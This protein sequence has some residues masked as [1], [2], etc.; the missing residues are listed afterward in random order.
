MISVVKAAVSL[1]YMRIPEGMLIGIEDIKRFRPSEITLITTGS[2]GE[3]MSA[4]HRM[5]YSEN[6]KTKINLGHEDLVVISATPIP[7]NEKLVSGIINELLHK[8]V[9]VVYNQVAD[10]HVSG[11]ACQDEIKLLTALVKPRFFVPMHGEYKHLTSN[12]ALALQVGIPQE[13][14]VIPEIGRTIEIDSRSIKLGQTVP[15]GKIMVDGLGVGDV[16]SVVLRDR[17]HLSED[18]LIVVV[19]AINSDGGYIT[20]GPDIVSR[21]FVYVKESE[22]L[23]DNVKAVATASVERAVY[24]GNCD[25]GYIKACLRDDLTKLLYKETKKK[26]MILPIIMDV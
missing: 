18:G 1:G 3:P 24:S 2:Q 20:S 16:G 9:E 25:F 5:T 11:H 26:P 22:T 4:L 14:I 17:K 6:E 10:V 12:K 19:V 7:G 23:M 13:N 21:G 8:G 15:S